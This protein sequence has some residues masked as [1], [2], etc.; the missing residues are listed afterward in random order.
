M[1]YFKSISIIENL[2]SGDNC[3]NGE[4]FYTS[5]LLNYNTLSENI[6]NKNICDKMESDISGHLAS[7]SNDDSKKTKFLS[8]L[9]SNNDYAKATSICNTMDP[10]SST[11]NIKGSLFK[12]SETNKLPNVNN[13]FIV[14]CSILLYYGSKNLNSKY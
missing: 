9:Y 7:I 12:K 8:I 2:Q 1:N 6:N 3:C 10:S 5:N 13:S 11:Y 14:C 4:T